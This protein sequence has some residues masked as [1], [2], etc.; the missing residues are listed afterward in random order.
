MAEYSETT[1]AGLVF[2]CLRT[3]IENGPVRACD[4]KIQIVSQTMQSK[5]SGP[6]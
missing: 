4:E 6:K 2:V 3:D 5:Q 1:M